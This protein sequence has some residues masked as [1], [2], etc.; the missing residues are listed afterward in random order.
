MAVNAAELAAREPGHEAHA[1]PINGGAGRERM[2]NTKL[3][4]LDRRARIEFIDLFAQAHAQVV[5][6]SDER[7][8]G[9]CGGAHGVQACGSLAAPRLRADSPSQILGS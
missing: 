3:T 1:R 4:A 8:F 5:G 6:A 2:N 7:N 9:V